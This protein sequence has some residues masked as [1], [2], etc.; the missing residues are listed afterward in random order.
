[1]ALIE[2]S[3]TRNQ[4]RQIHNVNIKRFAN[5]LW[6]QVSTNLEVDYDE[7]DNIIPTK[8]DTGL[9]RNGDTYPYTS[10]YI[11]DGESYPINQSDSETEKTVDAMD[12]VNAYIEI[13]K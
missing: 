10:A 4:Y 8:R 1:M 3:F 12:D 11:S 9:S 2:T 13:I 6:Q 5:I 7:M